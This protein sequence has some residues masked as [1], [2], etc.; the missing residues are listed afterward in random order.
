MEGL[1]LSLLGSFEATLDKQPIRSFRTRLAQAIL[2]YLACQPERQR[3]ETLMALFWPDQPQAAAQ[4]NLRQNLYFLRQTIAEVAARDGAQSVPLIL[5]DR[6]SLQI[7]PEAAVTVDAKRLGVLL[8]LIR[9]EPNELVEA[10]NL[11]RGN[12]LEDFYL[13]DN[14]DFEEWANTRRENYRRGIL[15]VLEKLTSL[16]QADNDLTQ[17]EMYARRQLTIDPLHEVANRQLIEILARAGRRSAALAQFDMYRELLSRDLQVFPGSETLALI[18]EIKT[19]EV[20]ATNSRPGTIRG[21]EI[22]EELGRG[23]FSTVF[24]ANQTSVSR[25]VAVKVIASRYADNTDFI[26]H[27]ESEAQIIAQLEHPHVVPLYDFWRE[28]GNAYLVMR[29]LRGGSLKTALA[30]GGWEIDKV[31]DL[32]DQV[33]SALHAA[34]ISGVIHRDVKPDNIL[35]DENGL[36]YLSDFGIAQLILP[37]DARK[38]NEI[39]AGTPDYISPEQAQFK[40]VTPLSDQYS[41]GLVIFECLTG[42]VPFK[43]TSMHELIQKHLYESVPSVHQFRRD[44][45]AKVND[46]IQQAIAKEP[47]ARYPD[48]VSFARAFRAAANLTSIDATHNEAVLLDVKNPYKGLLAFSEADESVFFGREAFTQQLIERMSDGPF[49]R[50]LTLVG[51]SGSGKS[52]LTKAGLIPAL[53]RGAIPG[54]EK[55]FFIDVVLGERPFEELEAAL[56]RIAVDPPSSLLEQLMADDR[57]LL[58]TVRNILP[59]NEDC[60]LTIIIDQFEELFTQAVDPTI[61]GQFI[62]S[63]CTAIDDP[64]SRL[65]VIIT[66]RA[67]YYDRPL[68]YPCFS[69]LMQQRTEIVTPLSPT[70]LT[71][72]I[73]RPASQVGVKVDSELVAALITDVNKQPG[74]LP[75]LQYTLSELF[76]RRDGNQLTVAEYHRIGGISGALSRRADAIYNELDTSDQLMTRT[77]FS[78]LV[79][80]DEGLEVSRKRTLVS[81]LMSIK[82]HDDSPANSGDGEFAPPSVNSERTPDVQMRLPQIIDCF[83]QANLL[84][85]DRDRATR[86]ATVEIAHESLMSAWPRLANWLDI[87]QAE[88]RS[89]RI[90]TEATTEWVG[91]GRNNGYLL[92]GARLDQLMPLVHSD[93]ALT[94]LER[95]LMDESLGAR[96]SRKQAE[97]ARQQRELI[98]A[99]ALLEAEQQRATEQT[100]ATNRLRQRATLLAIAL[101]I[102]A[103]AAVA[104][105]GFA[106]ESTQNA[107]IAATHEAQAQR[108]AALAVTREAEAIASANVAF[109]R[110]LS[111]AAT[112]TLNIDP[113]LS[114]LL[115]LQALERAE[116]KEAIQA[117]HQSLQ[118]MRVLS[119][120][121]TEA[122][123]RFGAL[124]AYNPAGDQVAT[125]TG[126]DL[127]LWELSTGRLIESLP[128]IEPSDDHYYLAFNEQGNGLAI[129]SATSEENLVTLQ[130]WKL[131][132]VRAVHSTTLPLTV[133]DSS[134]I[135]LSPDWSF[136]A[137]SREANIVEVWDL[138]QLMPTFTVPDLDDIVVDIEFDDEGERL[139][140]A[141]RKGEVSLWA[142]GRVDSPGSKDPVQTI[143]GDTSSNDSGGLVHIAFAGDSGLVL[144]YLGQVEI[145]NLSDPRNPSFTLTDNAK[146]TRDFAISPDLSLLATAGQDGTSH[147][148]NLHSGQHILTLAQHPSPIDSISF[149]LTADTLI[150]LDRDGLMRVWDS[151]PH[152]LGE[153]RAY[154]VDRGVFDIDLSPDGRQ[155]ALGNAGGPASIWDVAFGK[156]LQ[157]LPGEIGGVYRVDYSP[158]GKLLATVGTDNQIRILDIEL[159]DIRAS[160]SGHGAGLTS[161]LF[162]GTLD[163]AF[164]PDGKR[165]ATAGA[166]GVAKIWDIATG[167]ELLALTGH[168]DSLH[169]LAWSP[170]GHLLATTSDEDDTSIILWNAQSGDQIRKLEGHPVRAWGLD[171]S[172]DGSTLIT[173]GARGVIKAWDV[174]SGENI[175]TITDEPDHIGTV[176][177]TPDGEYFITSG[178]VPLRIR[179]IQDGEEV[180]TLADPMIWSTAVSHDG[181]WLYGADVDGIVRVFAIHQEDAV[182]LAHERLTRWWRTDE[183]ERYLYNSECPPPPVKFV[184]SSE[185]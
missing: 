51:P 107:E 49:H 105:L 96:E 175:Y 66:L 88:L 46:V 92:R 97:E 82:W 53:R 113:E 39:F 173:A 164:S 180:L 145:W 86:G 99:Q 125:A 115:A 35:L 34:H 1:S 117:L 75:L 130:T 146:L 29:Y 52:S 101:V 149:G 166:D 30:K 143:A 179:R 168:T 182:E 57:G 44:V 137:V 11:Y 79:R 25:D 55:W 127:L 134:I 165:L 36:A 159:G 6:D 19:G 59:K 41:L 33:A 181:R 48:V 77:L 109:S 119:S 2:I 103:I 150:T 95:Q 26:R 76:E 114:T 112:N 50:F 5:S 154:T 7:N 81:E 177:F 54:S 91:S 13:S 162:P 37:A 14:T 40:P 93:I 4:Q 47:A 85:F 148:W 139:A 72:A 121:N 70:E 8:H 62:Q 80:F 94:E 160:F 16:A 172:P 15:S 83:G 65:R 69:E 169:S 56:Q 24:R 10:V 142:T 20:N 120:F 129:V 61:T 68:L 136:L 74:A 21:Y 163:V 171:F 157:L 161:G 3:R 110:E 63:L 153:M 167:R 102:A 31:A 100:L 141:L 73:I 45:P 118:H 135:A 140:I 104:A 87:Y 144:G 170:D 106:R 78:R 9:P 178:E 152:L 32:L 124:F 28:P 138:D 89:R 126:S 133:D 147:I 60:E 158:D 174:S 151:R 27:F 23:A 108:N 18:A 123:G 17:A 122:A 12:F 58:R 71:H 43:A 84:S 131:D 42:Q 176:T 156:R 128:L 185:E 98:T 111:M 184:S 116:T 132:D 38:S 67:D 64:Q 90:L 22:L 155:M 183:C